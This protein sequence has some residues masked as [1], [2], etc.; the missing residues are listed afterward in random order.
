M[1]SLVIYTTTSGNTRLIAAAIADA[2]RPRGAVQ[3]MT[4]DETPATLPDA[5]VVFVGGPTERHA[6]TEPMVRFLDRT[7]PESLRGRPAAA[8]DTRLRW[9]RLL[10]GSAAVEIA[11]RLRTAGAQMAAPPESFIVSTKPEL[12]PGEIGRAETWANRV[13]DSVEARLPVLSSR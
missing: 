12:E 3:L 10:S 2:L 7:A 1:K 9:P 4:I 6:M 13:A 8:F 11:K 5:D